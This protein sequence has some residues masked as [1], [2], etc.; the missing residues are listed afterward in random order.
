[1][2]KNHGKHNSNGF[3]LGLLLGAGIALLLST[4]K[5]RNILKELTENGIDALEDVVAPGELKDLLKEDLEEEISPL[6]NDMP[7]SAEVKPTVDSS[8]SRRFFSGIKKKN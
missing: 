2:D 3:F 1:M 8:K 5:G 7:D 6:E 4:K